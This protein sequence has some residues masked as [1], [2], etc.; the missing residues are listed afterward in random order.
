VSE[1]DRRVFEDDY[2]CRRVMVVENGV[3]ERYFEPQDVLV[4]PNS[5][6]FTGSMD[7][8]PNQDGVRYFIEE[9][10]PAV[11]RTLPDA[12][13]TVVGR[14]P[15][16]WLADLAHSCPGV[17]VT[18]TVDDV[19]PF[20][21]E[22]ALYVVPLRVG[23][24]SRLKILE[25]LSMEKPVLSTT[26]GAEGLAVEDGTHLLVRDGTEPFAAAAVEMLTRPHRFGQLGASGRGLIMRHY[27]WDALAVKM[28][29]VWQKAVTSYHV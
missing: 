17:A 20:I 23:G 22:S 25:A 21:A 14:N 24:G 29:R 2:G 26:I 28:A 11:K 1:P 8:R 7:W 16:R 10:F 18:G 12:T 6:V 13:F 15:P 4:K 19:R 27:T 3:D 9:I 5:M